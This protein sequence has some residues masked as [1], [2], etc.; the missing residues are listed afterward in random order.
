MKAITRAAGAALAAVAFATGGAGAQLV[1]SGPSAFH[2]GMLIVRP[3][4]GRRDPREHEVYGHIV[5]VQKRALTLRLRSGRIVNVDTTAAIA[6][7]RFS[8]PLFPGK[9]VL[10][11]GTLDARGTLLA[12][13]I[14]RLTR[15][16]AATAGDR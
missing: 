3:V 12:Q 15:L 10:A 1:R 6:A 2:R 14:T 11:A 16:D 13:S 8:A 4:P 5:L 7:G 9:I